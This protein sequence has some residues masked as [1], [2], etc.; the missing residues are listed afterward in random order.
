MY[1]EN[2][3]WENLNKGNL[4]NEENQKKRKKKQIEALRNFSGQESKPKFE[5][6]VPLYDGL[7]LIKVTKYTGIYQCFLK[8]IVLFLFEDTLLTIKTMQKSWLVKFVFLA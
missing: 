4:I 1:R 2:S 8:K 6:V 3:F 7:I 5:R